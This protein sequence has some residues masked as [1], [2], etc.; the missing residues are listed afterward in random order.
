M[1]RRVT[2]RATTYQRFMRFISTG[3]SLVRGKDAGKRRN[4]DHRTPVDAPQPAPLAGA[5][6]DTIFA[7]WPVC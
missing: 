3:S 2:N 5:R 1:Q 4:A 7:A 6:S